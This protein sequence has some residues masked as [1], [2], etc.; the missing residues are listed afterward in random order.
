MSKKTLL[1]ALLILILVPGF[2]ACERSASTSE[3]LS[4]P[5][6]LTVM[7]TS[8]DPMEMLRGFATQTALAMSGGNQSGGGTVPT[9]MGGTP[10]PGGTTNSSSGAYT[11][12]YQTPT[13]APATAL[14]AIN[15]K[16]AS[17]TLQE[18]EFLYCIARRFDVN[19]AE[20]ASLNGLG[21]GGQYQPG[22]VLK[23]PQS[24]AP[25]PPPRGLL[26][27]PAKYTVAT[28]ESIYGIA[29]KY[30]DIDPLAIAAANNLVAPYT[31]KSGQ[32]I[33]IP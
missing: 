2:S 17:Y 6:S 21:L 23:I 5:T 31:L 25:F 14:P 22:L 19:P 12:V 26:T 32:V 13:S 3:P 8:N 16:P 33:T 10:M 1:Y 24:G 20:L 4:T 30:G 28:N 27:R 18:G 7:P 11:P 15:V 29:C 9:M